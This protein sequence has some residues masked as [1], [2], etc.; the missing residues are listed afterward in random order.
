MPV[1]DLEQF[2]VA[3]SFT[4]EQRRRL[5]RLVPFGVSC[6]RLDSSDWRYRLT[7]INSLSELSRSEHITRPLCQTMETAAAPATGLVC[8]GPGPGDGWVTDRVSAPRKWRTAP[9]IGYVQIAL[10]CPISLA[11]IERWRLD[12]K[13]RTTWWSCHAD[14]RLT[15]VGNCINEMPTCSMIFHQSYHL[16]QS[17]I[18]PPLAE[19][20]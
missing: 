7:Q 18:N 11:M 14:S 15:S 2:E 1:I 13:Q 12:D 6:Y 9:A 10:R 17:V 16:R 19:V 8:A 20:I 3:T 4:V 5:V